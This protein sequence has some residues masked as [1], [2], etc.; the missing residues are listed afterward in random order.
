MFRDSSL[1]CSSSVKYCFRFSWKM[2]VLGVAGGEI[3]LNRE[4]GGK[5]M[6]IVTGLNL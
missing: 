4:G 2:Q 3:E 5:G 6:E 1:F